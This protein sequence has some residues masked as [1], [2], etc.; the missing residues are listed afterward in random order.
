MNWSWKITRV[1]G[2]DIKIHATFLLL[3][4]WVAG[5]ALINGTGSSGFIISLLYVLAL[6]FFVTLH[7]LGHA[8]TARRFGIHTQDIVLLPIGGVSRMERL[9]DTPKEEFWI[10]AAGPLVNLVLALLFGGFLLL[11]GGLQ[12]ATLTAVLSFSSSSILLQF[13]WMN[14]LLGIFNLI[15][16]FPM[17]GGRILRA[18][19]ATRMP[20]PQA[21]RTAATIGQVLAVLF[22][23]AGFLW[24]PMLI[25]I[26]LFIFMGAGQEAQAAEVKSALSGYTARDAM[27][28]EFNVLHEGDPLSQAV[29]YV[30]STSQAEYPVLSGERVV[31]ILTR[32][33]LVSGL[34]RLGER[35]P[36]SAVMQR[37]FLTLRPADA[38]ESAAAQINQT[39]CHTMPVLENDQLVGLVTM[40]NIGEFLMIQSALKKKDPPADSWNSSSRP[41]VNRG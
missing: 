14:A 38:L 16:A 8:L 23:L 32:Q 15:P 27:L 10:T 31:G 20:A 30:V 34:Q 18:A 12:G 7:E 24:D 17:D 4:G 41:F 9:P 21:T 37:N 13:A 29:H 36:V 26:A 25:F 1:S 2:I 19:L 40:E 3:L 22:A 33:G 6:F 39:E 35:A 28:T 5:S 11:S